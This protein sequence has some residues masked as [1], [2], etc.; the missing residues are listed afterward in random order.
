MGFFHS[1]FTTHFSPL[2]FVI[3][4]VNLHK[5]HVRSAEYPVDPVITNQF[6]AT[7]NSAIPSSKTYLNFLLLRTVP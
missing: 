5:D 4:Y 3:A 2:K 1:P 7:V 6:L